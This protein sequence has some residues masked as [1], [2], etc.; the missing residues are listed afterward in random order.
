M[1]K[2][3]FEIIMLI[4]FGA[5][6]PVSIAK[7]WRAKTVKGKS[8]F[9]L[10]L[11]EVGYLAGIAHKIFYNKDFVIWLY[12]LNFVLV[13]TDILLYLKYREKN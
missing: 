8:L 7:T 13:G 3:I 2:S 12:A 9:F 4:C 6:W 11:I 1:S 10:L 5:S